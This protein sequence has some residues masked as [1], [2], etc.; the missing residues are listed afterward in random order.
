MPLIAHIDDDLTLLEAAQH[1]IAEFV[2]SV[3]IC[4]A[5]LADLGNGY[6]GDLELSELFRTALH[7]HEL[8]GIYLIVADAMTAA[9]GSRHSIRALALP[10]IRDAVRRLVDGPGDADSSDLVPGA[11][12][13]MSATSASSFFAKLER[14][15]SE[16]FPSL[17]FLDLKLDASGEKSGLE[18]LEK[19]KN[20]ELLHL[21]PVIIFS[22]FYDE[23]SVNEAYAR[24]A[25]AYHLK[26]GTQFESNLIH[27]LANWLILSKLPFQNRF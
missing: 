16:D 1:V 5:A 15:P 7:K 22:Q 26:G 25:S 8:P 6:D 21:V 18:L 12:I 20:H 9:F 13:V 11:S 14:L 10:V 24:G 19:I 3:A 27:L 2:L 17:I 4:E 23:R